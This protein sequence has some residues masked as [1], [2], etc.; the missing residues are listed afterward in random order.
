MLPDVLTMA[1]DIDGFSLPLSRISGS[2]QIPLRHMKIGLGKGQAEG[3]RRIKCQ[4]II[5]TVID[6]DE[7]I[8]GTAIN[9]IIPQQLSDI[10]IHF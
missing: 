1:A 6:I 4:V 10:Q 3:S 2:H 5:Q 8:R 9:A 7:F